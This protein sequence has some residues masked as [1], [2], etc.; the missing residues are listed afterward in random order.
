M[1]D[2]KT[3]EE[4][5]DEMPDPTEQELEDAADEL[6]S[7]HHMTAPTNWQQKTADVPDE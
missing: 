1:P 4:I 7:S 3:V 2:E 6:F 5:L